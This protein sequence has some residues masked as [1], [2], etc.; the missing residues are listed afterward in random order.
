V[1]VVTILFSLPLHLWVGIR[2][3]SFPRRPPHADFSVAQPPGWDY[4]AVFHH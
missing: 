2:E 3:A 4:L 1:G